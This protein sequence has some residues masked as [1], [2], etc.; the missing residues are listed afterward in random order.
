M[1]DGKDFTMLSG[2]D[3]NDEFKYAMPVSQL[4]GLIESRPG[5]TTPEIAEH[6]KCSVVF[7]RWSVLEVGML[8]FYD[9]NRVRVKAG[10]R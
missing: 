1:G 4:L 3:H 7:A 5:I 6:F 2:Q 9:G 8:E 10:D